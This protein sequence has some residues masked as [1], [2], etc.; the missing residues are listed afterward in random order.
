MDVRVFFGVVPNHSIDDRLR[1][2]RRRGVVEIDERLA[3]NA[4]PQERKV[5][6]DRRG[7]ERYRARRN[8]RPRAHHGVERGYR[9][10]G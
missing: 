4:L 1:L 7:V 8:R 3:A 2:L 6:T 9:V 5:L 10:V